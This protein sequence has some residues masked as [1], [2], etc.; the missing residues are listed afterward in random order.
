[1]LHLH[2]RCEP[3]PLHVLAHIS[4]ERVAFSFINR[5]WAKRRGSVSDVDKYSWSSLSGSQ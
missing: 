2:H 5:K 4:T 3:E 1:M